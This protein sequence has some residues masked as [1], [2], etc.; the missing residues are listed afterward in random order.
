MVTILA[1]ITIFSR[2]GKL[3]KKL[4]MLKINIMWNGIIRSQIQT[5][6]PNCISCFSF[7]ASMGVN[8]ELDV[9]GLAANSFKL[10]I[11]LFLPIF[12]YVFLYKWKRKLHKDRFMVKWGS[13]YS[14]IKFTRR[15]GLKLLALFCLRRAAFAF[16][17]VLGTDILILHLIVYLY[18]SLLMLSFLLGV[19]PFN[20]PILNKIEILNEF[21][22]LGAFYIIIFFTD[23]VTDVD[24]RYLSG[25]IYMYAMS[26]S[27]LINFYF[28]F[29][30]MLRPVRIKYKSRIIAIYEEKK[31]ARKEIKKK[32]KEKE[33]K[34]KKE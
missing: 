5:Y 22:S 30:E 2:F 24:F 28:V 10:A 21:F 17:I 3:S 20:Q 29:S 34:R 19:R 14:N 8:E 6:L 16:T 7:F 32:R 12:S 4:E 31:K 23:W 13:L 33:E 27:I 26:C 9:L 15:P 11:I 18:S 25:E 1:G